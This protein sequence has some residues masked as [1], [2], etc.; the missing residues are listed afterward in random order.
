MLTMARSNA[1]P[2]ALAIGRLAPMRG[3]ARLLVQS[4]GNHASTI[5]LRLK[6]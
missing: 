4:L 5:E 2:L 6:S 3:I 1:E